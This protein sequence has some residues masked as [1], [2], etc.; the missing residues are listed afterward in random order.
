MVFV[1]GMP[2]DEDGC[3]PAVTILRVLPHHEQ[4]RSSPTQTGAGATA[5]EMEHS[6]VDFAVLCQSPYVN[7]ASE[8]F[9]VAV[10]L[11]VRPLPSL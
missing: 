1:G 2:N 4:P 7:E 8:P 9:A 6:I 11:K 5:L 10:L 3:L